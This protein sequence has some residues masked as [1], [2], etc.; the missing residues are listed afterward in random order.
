MATSD[1]V[2]LLMCNRRKFNGFIGDCAQCNMQ[3][4]I[5]AQTSSGPAQY[6]ATWVPLS[7]KHLERSR[8]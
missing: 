5:G 4:N 1:E 3:V 2:T 8:G 7:R 6:I